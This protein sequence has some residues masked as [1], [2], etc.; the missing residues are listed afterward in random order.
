MKP[1][2]APSP[3]RFAPKRACG[4]ALAALVLLAAAAAAQ[5]PNIRVS[6]PSSTDPEEITIAINPVN[7]LNLV[8]G[9]NLRYVYHSQDGGLTWTEGRLMSS[10]G[11]WGDPC[12]IFDALG[13][14][15][16]GHLS[17]PPAGSG[18]WLD[19]IVVQKSTDGGRTWNAGAGIGL[20]PPKNQDKEWL[21]ADMTG[22]P[23]RNRLYCAWTEFD[24]YGSAL[25]TD[26]TRI[27]LAHST[28]G[29]ITWSTPARVSDRGGD[30]VDE[31]NTVE[32]AVPAVGPGGEVYLSWSSPGGIFF[33]RSTDGGVTWG[34]DV[35][36]TG[37]PGG[38]DFSVSGIYRCNGLPVTACDLSPSAYRGR[39]YVLWSDQR[40]G[41]DNTDVFLIRSDDGGATWGG[42]KQVNNDITT[43]H[44]FFPWMAI[45]QVN[46]NLFVVFYD[47]RNTAGDSTDVMVARSTDGGATFTNERVSASSFLPSASVFFGDYAGIAAHRGAVYPIWMRLD[48]GT[49]SNLSVWLA[50]LQDTVATAVRP[51]PVNPTVFTLQVYPNPFNPDARIRFSVPASAAPGV[52]NIP[53]RLE[54]FD[55]LGRL[56]RT[57]IDD[58]V[59]AGEHDVAVRGENEEGLPLSSG[60][61][62]V[63]LS[64]G[65]MVVTRRI[66]LLR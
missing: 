28:D 31:D 38:W 22:S 11:V 15:Y 42:L 4:G 13:N 51:S 32:G 8:A 5:T 17:N 16:Y 54:L 20:N 10:Y 23:Y 19:R 50:R 49:P 52:S 26:S 55:G 46:G 45:D 59:G 62:F 60:T 44:Q 64:G 14:A 66:L 30:C 6:S 37:Q 9:A 29:G 24:K 3:V 40:A 1:Q 63:R 33:D 48:S 43:R 61:Y 2:P 25:P 34:T 53:V 58:A 35:F 57:I 41:L 18:Y 36:V 7:P 27:L 56:V 12:V 47:R 65:G 39:I 21:A